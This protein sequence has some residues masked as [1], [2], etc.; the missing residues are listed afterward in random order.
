MSHKYMSTSDSIEIP[1]ALVIG[2]G[3]SGLT[4]IKQLLDENITVTCFEKENDIGGIFL[5]GDNKNGVYD[6]TV[7]TIGSGLMA[8][9]DFPPDDI[10]TNHWHHSDYLQYLRSYVNH[11]D[12]KQYI[13]FNHKIVSLEPLTIGKENTQWSCIIRNLKTDEE[14]QEIYDYVAVC[15]GTH[16]CP[17]APQ[18]KGIDNF[19]GRI[20][21]SSSYKNASSFADRR[22]M[23]IGLGESGADIVREVSNVSTSCHLVMRSYPDLIARLG[24]PFHDRN[25]YNA[26][27]YSARVMAQHKVYPLT[28]MFLYP[29]YMFVIFF[30]SLTVLPF[31]DWFQPKPPTDGF[32]QSEFKYLDLNTP[33]TRNFEQKMSLLYLML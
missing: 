25:Y 32:G 21:H 4:A 27:T 33:D 30:Y 24:A 12:L 29:F 19:K 2:A 8:F 14:F 10:G 13:H 18:F 15:I 3:A 26:D 9:S 17:K 5:F 11:F 28:N 31:I 23:L 20:M 6:S 1:R 16:Q 22:T 7:L